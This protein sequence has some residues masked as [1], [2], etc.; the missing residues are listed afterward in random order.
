MNY[1]LIQRQVRKTLAE[2]KEARKQ[3]DAILADSEVQAYF[4]MEQDDRAMALIAER[5]PLGD[6]QIVHERGISLIKA[7]IDGIPQVVD[8]EP[9]QVWSNVTAFKKFLQLAEQI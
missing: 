3:H 4:E 9:R 8:L 1:K 5:H 2:Y 7:M 6:W